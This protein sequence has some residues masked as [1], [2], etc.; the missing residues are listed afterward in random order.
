[1]ER[2]TDKS[3]YSTKC[4]NTGEICVQQYPSG[5]CSGCNCKYHSKEY[6][7]LIDYEDTKLTPEEMPEEITQLFFGSA[8]DIWDIAASIAASVIII[9]IHR[10]HQ[11]YRFENS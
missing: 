11:F 3:A 4:V 7:R 10:Y 6:K 2:L 8:F 5:H 9:L 1:M